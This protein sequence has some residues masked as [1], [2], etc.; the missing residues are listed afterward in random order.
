LRRS[1][2]GSNERKA[3]VVQ[4]VYIDHFLRATYGADLVVLFTESTS[5]LCGLGRL[6]QGNPDDGITPF[7]FNRDKTSLSISGIDCDGQTLAHEIGHNFGLNHSEIQGEVGE[8][9]D[10][11]RGYGG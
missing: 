1:A 5:S 2:N 9:A 11:G 4:S 7:K 6:G 3:V 8:V 10:Y